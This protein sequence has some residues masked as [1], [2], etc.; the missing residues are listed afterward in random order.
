M[1]GAGPQIVRLLDKD[2]GIAP[3]DA[4]ERGAIIDAR[5]HFAFALG[6]L[7]ERTPETVDVL[8]KTFRQRETGKNRMW[9]GVDGAMAAWALGKLRLVEA[10][11]LFRDVL[12][13]QPP[14]GQEAA[15][16]DEPPRAYVYWDL[17]APRFLPRAS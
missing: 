7:G 9:L 5:G 6:L 11:P 3:K 4:A 15:D 17:Q 8:L 12:L 14:Q 13:W 16:D 1:T 10:V 2:L